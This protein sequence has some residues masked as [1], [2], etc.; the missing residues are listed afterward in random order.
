MRVGITG[1]STLAQESVSVLA[2]ALGKVL[3]D[4]AAPVV[5]VTCLARGADQIFARTVLEA[6]GELEV[7]LPAA[8]YRD[9]KVKPDNRADFEAL[10]SS[11]GAV[12][13]S[14]SV[15]SA[16]SPTRRST[17]KGSPEWRACRTKRAGDQ[18]HWFGSIGRDANTGSGLMS[19]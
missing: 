19:G 3:A 6:G 16:M 7:I 12:R 15:I 13:Q 8:D 1:H 14:E 2:D 18:L 17:P 9:R 5:G 11:A 4:L 10:L